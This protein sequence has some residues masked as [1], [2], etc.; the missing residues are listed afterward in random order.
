MRLIDIEPVI[1]VLTEDL[2]DLPHDTDYDEGFAA[3]VKMAIIALKFA[4]RRERH[5]G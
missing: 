5:E 4:S 2:N 3:G 1:E